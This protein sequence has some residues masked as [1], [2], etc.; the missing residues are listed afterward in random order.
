VCRSLHNLL[1]NLKRNNKTKIIVALLKTKI[2]RESREARIEL[3]K[4]VR[5]SPKHLNALADLETIY[6]NLTLATIRCSFCIH[7]N[8]VYL[9][10]SIMCISIACRILRFNPNK[11]GT[12][13]R[14]EFKSISGE[15]M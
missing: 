13:F 9:A 3:E 14:P 11:P 1:V 6:R 5:E 2:P 8:I 12:I 4:I 7:L 10:L 15:G